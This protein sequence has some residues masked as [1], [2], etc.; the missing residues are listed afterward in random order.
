MARRKRIRASEEEVESLKEIREELYEEPRH[1][2]LA[3]VI[4]RLIT[5]YND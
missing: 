4:T 3:V 1:V 2:P 5:E